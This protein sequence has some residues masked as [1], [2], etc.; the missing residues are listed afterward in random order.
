MSDIK[1]GD[2]AIVVGSCCSGNDLGLIGEIGD[3]E[4]CEWQCVI[5]GRESGSEAMGNFVGWDS[6]YGTPLR[7]LRK[8]PPLSELEET[9][10]EV[11]A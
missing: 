5:C 7:W 3:I 11:A 6:D 8:I 4:V 1:V 2:L 9:F 10:E